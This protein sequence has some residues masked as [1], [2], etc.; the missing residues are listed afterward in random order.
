MRSL[1]SLVLFLF[2]ALVSAVSTAGNRMLVVLDSPKDKEA[3][4]TFFRDLSERGYQITYESP[5]TES[6][7]L[8]LHGERTYDHLVFLPTKIKGSS[9]L[10]SWC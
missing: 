6:L 10:V 7:A 3:Y 5:K 2:A 4:T 8:F 9:F 1:L